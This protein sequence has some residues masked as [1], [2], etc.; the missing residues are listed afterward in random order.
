MLKFL[1]IAFLFFMLMLS[2][3]GFSVIRMIKRTFFGGGGGG[4][5]KKGQQ[6]RQASASSSEQQQKKQYREESASNLQRKK[7][8][9]KEEGE[10]VDY[11]E[12]R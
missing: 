8:F 3:L 12:V 2:L 10:Y 11:E 7:I 5:E 6:R 4:N 9:T 1:A